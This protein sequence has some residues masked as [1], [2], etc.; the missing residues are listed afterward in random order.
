MNRTRRHALALAAATLLTGSAIAQTQ[1]TGPVM[2]PGL[3]TEMA[4]LSKQSVAPEPTSEPAHGAVDTLGLAV[5]L[6][7]AMRSIDP[8]ITIA[9]TS[10][11][12]ALKRGRDQLALAERQLHEGARDDRLE[13]LSTV[14]GSMAGA[15]SA[16][17]EALTIAGG[18]Q[19]GVLIGLLL[20]AVQKVRE[21][22]A[23]AP[24][25]LIDQARRAGVGEGRLAPAL[26]AMRIAESLIAQGDWAGGAQQH[27][28]ALGMAANTLV[29]SMDRFESNLKSVFDANSVGWSY[30]LTK[31]GVLAKSDANGDARTVSD[32]PRTDQSP[33]KPMHVASVSKM[34]T[35]IVLLRRLQLAGMSVS[36]K[37]DR[38]LP[39]NWV[40]GVGVEDIS[41]RDL[42]QHR[43][44]FGQNSP[45]GSDYETLQAMVAQPVPFAGS[46]DYDNANFGL[47]RV[48]IAKSAAI[49]PADYPPGTNGGTLTAA[50]F[51]ILA[52]HAFNL[53]GV[54][55]SCDPEASNPTR[56][57][58]FPDTGNAGYA[59]P[60]RSL[61]C[62]GFGTNISAQD[63]ARTMVNLRYTSTLIS[64]AQFQTM[65]TGWLGFSNPADGKSY[66]QGTFGAYHGHGGDW[67]HGA[68][69]LDACVLMFPIHVEAAVLVNS[70]RAALGIG[71]PNGNYQCDV[72][73]WAFENAWV[74]N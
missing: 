57:Y 73:K 13:F 59:E 55:Y 67:D 24:A 35:A 44:G 5:A 52:K 45:G 63:L 27:A 14:V 15:Q 23:R 74:A 18:S 69:G 26:D 37:I 2:L 9:P 32:A 1:L 60:P 4:R 65:K 49:D 62:G 43:S 29:F 54:P 10:M 36:T 58:Q 22:A 19:Q 16:F 33:T 50:A 34:L 3:A 6:P 72:V 66:A 11:R 7:A 70:S 48:L 42:L 40:R 31:G 51:S 12:A 30:A 46:Y 68:G 17:G 71:Y 61:S 28:Q 25:A 20:P 39:G 47:M 53:A 41:F 38:W 56:Q 21:A 8:I 64:P